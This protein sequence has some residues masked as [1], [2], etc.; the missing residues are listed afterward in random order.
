MG[1]GID[2]IQQAAQRLGPYAQVT[3]VLNSPA[4]DRELGG[5]FYLKP[6]CLQRTGSF[7]FRGAYNAISIIAKR[8]PGRPIV[9]YSSGNHAQGVAAA[10]GICGLDAYIV[11]P[12]DAPD[13]K[14]INT[15]SHGASIVG[16]DRDTQDRISI[17]T[18]LA[19]DVGG[20]IVPPFDH[21]HIIAGQGTVGLE[22]IEDLDACGVKLDCLLVPCSGGGLAA[23]VALACEALSPGTE[24][25]GCE[26]EGFDDHALSLK[27]GARVPHDGG[28]SICDALMVDKP[29]KITFG[30]NKRLLAG[31]ISIAD[32]EVI[33]AV[34]YAAETFKL[35]VEP[36]GAIALAAVLS[37]GIETAG[38]SVGIVLSGGNIDSKL[39]CD[40]LKS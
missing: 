28:K 20:V 26:P 37:G 2:D 21:E 9:A 19:R 39:L 1:V 7:K 11:M 36:S 32:K 27:A 38:K 18:A 35:V 29:G 40:I 31:A 33:R 25:Y 24:V 17:A 16:Y 22:F 30:I 34:A 15:Q 10:A 3:P 6:E 13:I 8:D 14:R 5:K 23:G 4:L 12:D